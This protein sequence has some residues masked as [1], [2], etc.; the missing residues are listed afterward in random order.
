[1]KKKVASGVQIE[2][3]SVEDKGKGILLNVYVYNNQPD[4]EIDYLTGKSWLASH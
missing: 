4:V 2:A 3:E 1:M